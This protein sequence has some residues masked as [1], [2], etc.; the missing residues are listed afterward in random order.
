MKKILI[1]D[2]H[3]IF[4][5][6]MKE[7]LNQEDDL[8]V[9]GVAEDFTSARKSLSEDPPDLAIIDIS[10]AEENGLDLVTGNTDSKSSIVTF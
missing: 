9:S 2:D 7:L 1:V 3:P 10:L 4:R 8:T 5:M 6:G